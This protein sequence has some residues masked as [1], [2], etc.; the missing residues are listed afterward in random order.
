M[1]YKYSNYKQLTHNTKGTDLLYRITIFAGPTGSDTITTEIDIEGPLKLEIEL[2]KI[3]DD[4]Y[5]CDDPEK[6]YR[7][8]YPRH[9]IQKIVV[10]EVA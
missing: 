5:F 3:A 7:V 4:G 10:K 6:P 9:M 2:K 1:I 8:F